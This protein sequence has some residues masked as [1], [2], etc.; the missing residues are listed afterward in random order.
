[1]FS[2]F[3]N[4]GLLFLIPYTAPSMNLLITARTGISFFNTILESSPLVADYIKNDSRGT[5]VAMITIGMLIGEAFGMAFLIGVTMSM[6]LDVS[7]TFAVIVLCLMTVCGSFLIREPK[8]KDHEK[9]EEEAIN[10]DVE[11]EN[12]IVT[13]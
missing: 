11:L 8:I 13:D 7:F 5:A 10:N 6:D 9:I 4:I 12:D 3:A 1:M 2:I